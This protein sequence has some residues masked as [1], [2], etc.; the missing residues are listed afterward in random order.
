MIQGIDSAYSELYARGYA[1]EKFY[2]YDYAGHPIRIGNKLT[3][4]NT[5]KD[6]VLDLSSTAT[7]VVKFYCSKRGSLCH[8]VGQILWTGQYTTQIEPILPSWTPSGSSTQ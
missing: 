4:D 6:F 5:G 2:L 1:K 3:T 8:H 7:V